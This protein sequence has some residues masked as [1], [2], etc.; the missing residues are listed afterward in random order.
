MQ[1]RD[2]ASL[3]LARCR[4]YLPRLRLIWADG[5]YND[6]TWLN[7]VHRKYN[8][9]IEITKRPAG[10]KGFVVIPRRWVVERSIAWLNNA[11]RLSKDYEYYPETS[12]AVVYLA[13][14]R[15]YLKHLCQS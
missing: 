6:E 13:S 12:A 8:V 3:I 4:D 2:G 9:E 1:D 14:I 5:A 10:Q 7:S 11:R 15:R